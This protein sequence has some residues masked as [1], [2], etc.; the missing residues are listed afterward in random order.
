MMTKVENMSPRINKG[1]CCCQRVCSVD[2]LIAQ[3]ERLHLSVDWLRK[4]ECSPNKSIHGVG[5]KQRGAK[6]SVK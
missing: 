1:V 4:Q 2:W 6:T 3:C 5:G